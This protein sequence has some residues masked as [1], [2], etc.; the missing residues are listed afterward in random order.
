MGRAAQGQEVEEEG[1]LGL[2]RSETEI[3]SIR[4]ER[5]AWGGGGGGRLTSFFTVNSMNSKTYTHL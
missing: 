3:W 2:V 5:S 4:H 1:G